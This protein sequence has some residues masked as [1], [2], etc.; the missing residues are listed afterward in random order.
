MEAALGELPH[1]RSVTP[2]ETGEDD[3]A[4]SF[5][6]LAEPGHDPWPDLARLIRDK[7]WLVKSLRE[8][9]PTLEEAFI[10]L[11]R[12]CKEGAQGA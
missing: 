7:G 4:R 2:L 8:E 1:I 9:K 11:T 5:R 3:G 12:H 6:L 10:Q